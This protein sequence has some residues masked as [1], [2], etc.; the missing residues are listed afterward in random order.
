M[1]FFL[2][3][4]D[5]D[6]GDTPIENIFINDYMPMANGT[7]V[8]VYLIGYKYAYDRDY[9]IDLN[10]ETIAKHLNI[11]LE[12][13]LRAWDFWQS[14]GIIEKIPI[15]DDKSINYKVK[16]LSLKQL[17]IK[18]NIKLF[19]TEEVNVIRNKN[20]TE[21]LIKANKIPEINNM[22]N[23]IDNIMRRQTVPMEKQKILTWITDYNMNPDVIEKAFSYG[24]ERKGVRNLNYVEGIVRNW[25]DEGLTNMEAI[26]EYFRN[27]DEK[28]YLYQKIM[29][30]LGLDKRPIRDDEAEIIDKWF[31]KYKFDLDLVLKACEADKNPTPSIKYVNGILKSWSKKGIKTIEDIEI[32]DKPVEKVERAKKTQVRRS[33]AATTRFH[34]FEQRSDNYTNDQLEEIMERK[35][36]EAIERMKKTRGNE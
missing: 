2:E 4:T 20:T 11:P 7:Y 28:Y 18:N 14:K 30:S 24:V 22:F 27:K 19:S 17:Y 12:D 16:F 1:S 8:K 5:M 6:L 26:M 23:N 3:T 9:K 29:K 36:Q 10:N 35:R 13:V 25:Y 34:N 31:E 15:E 33:K 21:D 32:L